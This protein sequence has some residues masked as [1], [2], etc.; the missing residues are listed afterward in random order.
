MNKNNGINDRLSSKIEIE[1]PDFTKLPERV[2]QKFETVNCCSSYKCRCR[3]N[4]FI[5]NNGHF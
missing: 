5:K 4:F 3:I 2:K 1:F